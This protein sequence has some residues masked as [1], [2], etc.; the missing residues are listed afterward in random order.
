MEGVTYATIDKEGTSLPG[1]ES[2]QLFRLNNKDWVL[3]KEFQV[4]KTIGNTPTTKIGL[5][6]H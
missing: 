5:P 6:F 3:E 1:V 2:L 4:E